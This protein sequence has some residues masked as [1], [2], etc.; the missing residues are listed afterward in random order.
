VK[1]TD[2]VAAA[3]EQGFRVVKGRHGWTIYP[4]DR[5]LPVAWISRNAGDRGAR[6][7]VAHARRAGVV[8]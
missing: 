8:I 4:K 2:I 5:S 6:N 7:N 3:E 1:A